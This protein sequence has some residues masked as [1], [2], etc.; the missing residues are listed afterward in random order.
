M[1]TTPTSSTT[2]YDRDELAVIQYGRT[3]GDNRVTSYT[4]AGHRSHSHVISPNQ[5]WPPPDATKSTTA[6]TTVCPLRPVSGPPCFQDGGGAGQCPLDAASYHCLR[7]SAALRT[8]S[9]SVCCSR[10]PTIYPTPDYVTASS[11]VT[12]SVGHVTK[13]GERYPLHQPVTS[14]PVRVT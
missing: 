13:C 8:I 14:L 4:G 12:S 11:D 3:S 2:S 7:C 9:Q 1:L 10:R 5:R 6:T